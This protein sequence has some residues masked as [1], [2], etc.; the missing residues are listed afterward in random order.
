MDR[1]PLADELPYRFTPPRLSPFWVRA[2]RPYR[3]SLLRGEHRLGDIEVAGAEAIAPLLARGDGIVICP[4]HSDRADGL[5][6]LELLQRL[7]HPC[8]GM[9]AYQIF[10]GSGGIRY[11]LFPRLGVFPV[12]RE[13]ADLSAFRAAGQILTDGETP[14]LLFPE[15]EV[16]HTA[17][18]LTPL[19]DGVAMLAFR[20]AKTLA[21]RGRT[22]RIV[23][24][25]I[26][27]RFDEAHDP[28][29]AF[30]ALLGR[31]ESKFTWRP[32]H[33]TP[34]LDRIYRVAEAGQ[35][36]KELEYHGE[37]R[38][39][40]LPDRIAT[41]RAHLLESVAQRRGTKR[42]DGTDPER[43]K[44]LRRACLAIL[45]DPAAPPDQKTIARRDL[46]DLFVAAQTF[47]Y[48]GDY[49]RSSPTIERVAETLMKFDEDFLGTPV[50]RPLGPRRA[51]VRYGE[52]IDVRGLTEGKKLREALEILTGELARRIQGELDAIGPGRP[53]PDHAQA[54]SSG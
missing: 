40:P 8:C 44:E 49:V 43:I 45:T 9:A 36:L 4:N 12:D 18:R 28:L 26:K 10:A 33:D 31:V 21:E 51:V 2:T 17:D 54:S 53:L 32:Q 3:S 48:P 22:V 16:Y 46:G 24:V 47:S 13:G 1:L 15:G 6:M 52:P 11:W 34:V 37:P 42:V 29:P 25:G 41:L 7:G 5:L 23:P 14:L 20:A 19:R 27:Y 30:R 50:A 38:P 35:T 39:G